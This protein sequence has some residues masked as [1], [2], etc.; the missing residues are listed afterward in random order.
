MSFEK[1]MKLFGKRLKRDIDYVAVLTQLKNIVEDGSDDTAQRR[2][3]AQLKMCIPEL[4]GGATE[5]VRSIEMEI[6][7]GGNDNVS[8]SV[9][10]ADSDQPITMNMTI[11]WHELTDEIREDVIRN[12]V[13]KKTL[14]FKA[15]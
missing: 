14:Y 6:C 1:L 10:T 15:V 8:I 3:D 9:F 5:D 12:D 13:H 4:S 2:L 11:P 7:G